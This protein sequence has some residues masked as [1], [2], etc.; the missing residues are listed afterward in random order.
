MLKLIIWDFD[1]VIAD[2]LGIGVSV[3]NRMNGNS[4]LPE[5][6]ISDVRTLGLENFVKKFK[7]PFY[8]IPGYI[9]RIKEGVSSEMDNAKVFPGMKSVLLNLKGRYKL[10]IVTTNT[11][12]NVDIFLNANGMQ[13]FFDFIVA[14]AGIFGKSKRIEEA[15][16]DAKVEKSEAICIGDEIRDVKAAKR[17]T[18]G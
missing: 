13:E 17:P 6:T 2:T 1:G 10:G 18:S 16:R 14:G 15:I 11:R 3:W 7:I 4:S 5:A 12:K 8:K 9:S